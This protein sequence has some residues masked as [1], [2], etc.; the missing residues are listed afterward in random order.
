MFHAENN[1]GVEMVE[2][3]SSLYLQLIMFYQGMLVR[4]SRASGDALVAGTP[5]CTFPCAVAAC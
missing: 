3:K 4:A 2:I 1:H 5:C